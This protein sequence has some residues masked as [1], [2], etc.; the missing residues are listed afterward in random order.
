VFCHPKRGTVYRADPFAERLKAA[1]TKTGVEGR[2]R[3]FHDLRHSAITHDAAVG[4]SA[5]AVMQKAGHANMALGSPLPPA[6]RC[7]C[8]RRHTVW[9][10]FSKDVLVEVAVVFC[11]A[12]A[13]LIAAF[14][15]KRKPA[16]GRRRRLNPVEE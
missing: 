14:L 10:G 1:L 11:F 8:R 2:F 5:I 13:G 16:D 12:C 6:V 3:A 9:D 7:R 15:T 4:S